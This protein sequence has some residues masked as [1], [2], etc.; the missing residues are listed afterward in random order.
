MMGIPESLKRLLS[1]TVVGSGI[2][3]NH[4]E[5]H[6]V[7]SDTTRLGIMNLNGSDG[8]NLRLLNIEEA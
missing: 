4:A 3:Q 7:T 2:H 8:S 6:D 1:D 5:Q